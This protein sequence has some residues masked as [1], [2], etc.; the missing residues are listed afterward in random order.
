ML[1]FNLIEFNDTD[2]DQLEEIEELSSQEIAVIG[3]S[4]KLPLVDNLDQFWK[5]VRGGVDFISE[6]PKSR[7]QDTDIYARSRTREGEQPAY[8][9]GA[10]LEDIDCFDHAFS[11][12]RR[13]KQ[14]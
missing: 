7:R 2:A 6:F 9:D 1:D 12:Y 14:A 10:Y 11:V 4:A 5:F 8:F 3:I 13:R